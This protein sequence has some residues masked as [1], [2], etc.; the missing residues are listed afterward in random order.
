MGRRGKGRK[1][2]EG[3]VFLQLYFW[4]VT[5]EKERKRRRDVSSASKTL[6]LNF[7]FI[8]FFSSHFLR[9]PFFFAEIN[10]SKKGERLVLVGKWEAGG[11]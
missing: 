10:G 9:F 5:T 4:V 2:K 7:F 3:T 6:I 8:P 1:R 11:H